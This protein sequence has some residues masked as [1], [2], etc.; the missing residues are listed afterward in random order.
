VRYWDKAGTDDGGKYSAGV[1]MSRS[2]EGLVFVEN[3]TRG[4]WGALDRERVIEQTADLDARRP[5][6]LEIWTEQEPGSGGKES[7]ENTIRR[8]ARYAI[9]ADKVTG[10]K[11]VR[12]DPFAAQ[13]E[14]GNVYLVRGDWN[15]AYIDELCGVP[16][17]KYRDQADASAGA[18]NKLVGGGTDWRDTEGLGTVEEYKSRWH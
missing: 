12:L 13:A 9:Y 10:S 17:G 7:A 8:L 11:D 3:S 1:L 16:N 14:A 6:P 4:Q 2:P 15:E 18:Y 5:G